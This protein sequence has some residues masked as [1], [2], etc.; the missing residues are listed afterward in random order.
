MTAKKKRPGNTPADAPMFV[1]NAIVLQGNGNSNSDNISV[2]HV[3]EG[4][5]EVN[6]HDLGIS[7]E[8]IEAMRRIEAHIAEA[9]K[10]R[11]AALEVG[12]SGP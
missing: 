2:D 6:L 5:F 4:D 7:T 12:P 8:D 3:A 1:E 9:Q 11:Q 10:T